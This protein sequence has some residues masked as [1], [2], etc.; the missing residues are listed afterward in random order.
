MLAA[1]EVPSGQRFT[2]S[3]LVAASKVTRLGRPPSG[4]FFEDTM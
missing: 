1:W 2:V 3:V 4:R